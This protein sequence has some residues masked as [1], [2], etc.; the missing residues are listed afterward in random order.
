MAQ[1]ALNVVH[2]SAR[3]QG[4]RGVGVA[5][6]P[7]IDTS[8]KGSLADPRDDPSQRSGFHAVA[9]TTDED[10]RRIIC[11]ETHQGS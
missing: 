6:H 8:T 4:V 1:A 9:E 2:R 10:R 11:A 7:G 5:E 3:F